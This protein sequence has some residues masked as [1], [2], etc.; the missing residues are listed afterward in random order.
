MVKSTQVNITPHN[1]FVI[2]LRHHGD[3]ILT[4]PVINSLHERYPNA[5][6]DVLLYKETRP[7]L[8]AHPAIRCLHV[9]DRTWKQE[10]HWR[11]LRY[12]CALLASVRAS[13]YDVVVNLA[14]QWRSALI[15]L[16]SG[17]SL[18]I[19]FA[20]DKR[21][22]IFWRL[23]HNYLVPTDNHRH[24]HTVEQNMTALAPFGISPNVARPSMH[25]S[26]TDAQK[27]DIL[28]LKQRVTSNFIIFHP[29][30]RW[31]FKCW[32]DEKVATTIDQLAHTGRK[33]I[34]TSAP[35]R[36]ELEMI[37]RI[38]SL[39]TTP[40]LISLAGQLSLPQ[41]A[42]LIIRARLFMGVDSAPMHMSAALGI[43]CIALLGP[44]K[45]QFWRPWGGEDN[46][47]IWAGDYGPLPDP[48]S[49]DTN[50]RQRYLSAIPVKD[51]VEIAKKVL[52]D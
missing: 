5:S 7:I 24:L 41:L 21:K 29:T 34:L 11:K 31:E 8:E 35:E 20:F 22:S 39:C 26:E 1:I 33:V 14:D 47:V 46:R 30:A 45:L 44:T 4:T 50:T 17:A 23:C 42:A 10:G 9:I 27:V 15:T 25:F 37:A 36:Y 3:M 43:P 12:E 49:I 48:D 2:K 52:N 19:G 38:Q 32:E 28:L 18:R 40:N 16:F 6:I 51:V 13:C